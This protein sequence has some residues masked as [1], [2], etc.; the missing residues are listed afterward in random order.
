VYVTNTNQTRISNKQDINECHSVLETKA[1]YQAEV[2]SYNSNSIL[3]LMPLDLVY[4]HHIFSLENR[5]KCKFSLVLRMSLIK[6][7]FVHCAPWSICK[8]EHESLMKGVVRR[9]KWKTEKP[10][11]PKPECGGGIINE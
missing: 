4:T 7:Q 11:C 9:G 5:I 10:F 3:Y 1:Q 2:S 8:Q 6:R